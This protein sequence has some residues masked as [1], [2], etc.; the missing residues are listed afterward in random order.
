M[1]EDKAMANVELLL[2]LEDEKEDNHPVP[3][4]EDTCFPYDDTRVLTIYTQMDTYDWI[5]EGTDSLAASLRDLIKLM[6]WCNVNITL[7]SNI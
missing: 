4:E 3:K 2:M 7:L 1:E 6:E 5:E